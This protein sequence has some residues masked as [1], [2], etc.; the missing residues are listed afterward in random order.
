MPWKLVADPSGYIFTWLIGY[1]ALL[2][3]IGGIL[4]ADYFVYRRMHLPLK[5]LYQPD[6]EFRFTNGFSVVAIVALVL[7]VL[8]NLPGF[9]ITIGIWN[10]ANWPGFFVELYH[11]AW[12][13]G[14]A[15]AF[16]IYLGLRN[17]FPR[18]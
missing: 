6:G 10:P 2:G 3:P 8:P 12:F 15:L 14:F 4:I 13:V 11:Y 18:A 5:A 9:L 16:V 17:L 1:S 7:A